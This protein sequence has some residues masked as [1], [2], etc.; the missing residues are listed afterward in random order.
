MNDSI[1]LKW[2]IIRNILLY[3]SWAI[4]YHV[5]EHSVRGGCVF[6]FYLLLLDHIRVRGNISVNN[7]NP[8]LRASGS[9]VGRGGSGAG[10]TPPSNQLK[11]NGKVSGAQNKL[12]SINY[13]SGW[14]PS[15]QTKKPTYA[16]TPLAS[17]RGVSGVNTPLGLGV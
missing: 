3:R 9:G 12:D 5:A 16:A 15:P 7:E 17:G 14:S 6:D 13:F 2:I 8:Q 10:A 1:S 4:L 11:N